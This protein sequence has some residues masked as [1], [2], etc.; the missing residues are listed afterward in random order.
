LPHLPYQVIGDSNALQIARPW[1]PGPLFIIRTLK[2]FVG[3]FVEAF[4]ESFFEYELPQ[5]NTVSDKVSD[6]VRKE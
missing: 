5:F 1:F 6:K 3:N 2:T 4:I